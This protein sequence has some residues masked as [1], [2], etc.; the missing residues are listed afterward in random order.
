MNT[1]CVNSILID[2]HTKQLDDDDHF[3]SWLGEYEMAQS[4][5][6]N[7]IESLIDKNELF[8]LSNAVQFIFAN[9]M[10]EGLLAKIGV[11]IGEDASQTLHYVAAYIDI[12]DVDELAEMLVMAYQRK[13]TKQ[14]Y[15]LS[16]LEDRV[17][18]YIDNEPSLYQTYQD[19]M[20][21][22]HNDY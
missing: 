2:R 4:D 21:A 13:K 17:I 14:D 6:I 3:Q 12:L 10:Q 7:V 16:E 5:F 11:A 20:E 19:E 22:R 8:I 9:Q 1:P 18:D 15:L